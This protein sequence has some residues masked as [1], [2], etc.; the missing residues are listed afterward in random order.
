MAR[1]RLSGAAKELQPLKAILE[2]NG[3]E[4][5][6]RGQHLKVKKRSTNEFV[7]DDKGPVIFSSTPGDHR[8]RDM[9]VKRLIGAGVMKPEQNPW[10]PKKEQDGRASVIT[11]DEVKLKRIE[12]MKEASRVRARKT[13]I[14]RSRMEP[15]VASLGGWDKRGL[16]PELA[17]TAKH[18]LASRKRVEAWESD[19][20]AI[21]NARQLRMGATLSDKAR[22]AWELFLDE[23]DRAEDREKR[24]FE[25][26]RESKGLA[27]KEVE[28][29]GQ[30]PAPF[31]ELKD[32]VREA[33]AQFHPVREMHQSSG[34]L[35]NVE[36]VID[37]LTDLYRTIGYLE[38]RHQTIEDRV[39]D[40]LKTLAEKLA[41]ARLRGV[42][43]R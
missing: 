20:G 41:N 34:H 14:L 31:T 6:P 32:Q 43:G 35:W 12:A 3:Y 5:V 37:D 7:T 29:N 23:L 40:S 33:V 13:Q 11:S 17:L 19:S 25:L 36:V 4:L 27:P 28:G 16:A 10:K 21:Q 39:I 9:H 26:V 22:T 8:A 2:K 24:Y 15:L 42:E 38:A 1:A 18:Y 30:Q